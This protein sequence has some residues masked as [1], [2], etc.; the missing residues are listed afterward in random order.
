M[1][2]KILQPEGNY[3]DKYGSKNPIEKLIMKGFFDSIDDMLEFSGI[4]MMGGYC[5]EAGCGEGNLTQHISNWFCKFDTAVT[6]NA[7][8]ISEKLIE[9]N[10]YKF[11]EISFFTHNIYENLESKFI[12]VG[13]KYNLIVCSEVLEHLERPKDAIENLKN[14]GNRFIISVPNEPL[15]RILNV[16]RGKYLRDFGNTPGHIQHFSMKKFCNM[17]NECG[18]R[19][20]KI[21]RPLPWLMVYCE[22]DI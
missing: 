6:F 19:V 9:E 21:S 3:Y 16:V 22:Y 13:E 11:S 7:F 12:P 17:L 14:Y 20:R 10:K 5:L 15:W 8:D 4:A 18:L 2:S 1:I